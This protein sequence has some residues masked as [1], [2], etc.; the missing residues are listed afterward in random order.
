MIQNKIV[1]TDES[2]FTVEAKFN[3]QSNWVLAKLSADIEGSTRTVFRLQKPS[4]VMV[5]GGISKKWRS[6]LIF[7]EPGVKVNTNT[8]IEGILTPALEQAKKHFKDDSF[9]FQQDGA[10]AHTSSK[11][12]KWCQDNFPSFRNKE[13]WPPSSP[14]LN[15]MDY[16][17]WGILE[18]EACDSS[19]TSVE[20]LKRSLLKAWGKIPQEKLRNPQWVF[21]PDLSM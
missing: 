14:D 19:H 2:L 21:G 7:V 4:S 10:P 16:C 6:S 8:Y 20:A 18:S 5:W 11:T 1:F 13:L 12:Q 9:T 3:C 17:V 15:P